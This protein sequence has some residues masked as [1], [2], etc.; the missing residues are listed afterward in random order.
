MIVEE[1]M[2]TELPQRKLKW[3]AT[4]NITFGLKLRLVSIKSQIMIFKNTS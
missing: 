1:A 3:L 4:S 2:L